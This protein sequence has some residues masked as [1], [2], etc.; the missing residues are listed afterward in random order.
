VNEV[1]TTFPEIHVISK[2]QGADEAYLHGTSGKDRFQGTQVYGRL[3][4]P[5]DAGGEFFHRVVRFPN[6]HVTSGGGPDV[7]RLTDSRYNDTLEGAPGVCVHHVGHFDQTIEDF[8]TVIASAI[9][10]GVDTAN[11]RYYQGDTVVERPDWTAVSGADYLVRVE[12]YETV[13]LIPMEPP[14]ATALMAPGP[15][16]VSGEPTEVELSDAEL[17]ALA[18]A[19]ATSE[20]GSTDDQDDELDHAVAEAMAAQLW[21]LEG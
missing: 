7:A 13:N 9:E 2:R 15:G 3:A 11:V 20:T 19:H 8:P 5:R 17:S 6:T 4:G 10:S 12:K 1:D 16:D 18:L 14:S 21:W